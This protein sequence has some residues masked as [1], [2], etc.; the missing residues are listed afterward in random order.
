MTWGLPQTNVQGDRARDSQRQKLYD[1]E[2]VLRGHQ[3]AAAKRL[4]DGGPKVRTTGNVSIEA[5]QQ[6]VD[7]VTSSAAFQ[8]RFGKQH[9][10]V[11][12]K[13]SGAATGSSAGIYLPPGG[14]NEAVIL[15]EV[16]HALHDRLLTGYEAQC[17]P[18]SAWHGP[19]FAAM[20][21]TLVEVQVGK[22]AAKALRAS[23]SEHRVKYRPGLPF[24]PKPTKAVET[25]AEA[26]KKAA[27]RRRAQQER[28]NRPPSSLMLEEAVATIRKALA[29]GML[30]EAG[31]KSRKDA[32]AT[33]RRLEAHTADARLMAASRR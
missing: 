23:F 31:S 14:R 13:S 8:R 25:R 17:G 32:L 28:A 7:H 26:A 15:H 3:S 6:Y 21:L 20:L 19:V 9:V 10:S 4:L 18:H 33:A 11:N 30:G 24:M 27:E 1:A 29:A 16:A 22:E 12:H 5:C 2:K